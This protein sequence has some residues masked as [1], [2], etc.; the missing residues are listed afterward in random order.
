MAQAARGSADVIVVGGGVAGLSAAALLA[1]HLRVQLLE[2]EPLLASQASANNAAIHRPLE[3]DARSARLA[4]RSR[5]L[6]TALIGPQ[7]HTASGLL[8]VSEDAAQVTAL[9]RLASAEGVR[10]QVLDEPGLHARAPSLAG[11]CARHGLLLL[12][13]GVL[14][15]HALTSGLAHVARA[16]GAELRTGVRVACVTQVQGRVTGVLLADGQQLPAQHVVLA[17]G[18][19]SA[20]LAAASGIALPLT[21]LRRHLVQLQAAEPPGPLEPVVWRLE[22]EIYYRH[23][24]QGLLASPCDETPWP[25]EQPPNDPAALPGL[26]QK[27]ERLA[28]VLLNGALVRRSWACLRTFAPDREL[29]AGA[30]ARVQGLH[31]LA[32]LGGRGMSV[33]TAAAEL[34]VASV[35]GRAESPDHAALAPARFG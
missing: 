14:D 3:Q 24:A 1:A 21:P 35:L 2:C 17:A 29:V 27:L 28:P 7:V 11:G 25:A 18:A 20:I 10:Y 13:G 34:L 6:L 22:D 33:A 26:T 32:G 31:W 5:E 16:R 30:D 23:Q 4:R 12:D 15:L 8:L 19:W 9:S